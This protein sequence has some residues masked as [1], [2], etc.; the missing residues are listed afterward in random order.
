[1]PTCK[2]A[3]KMP[4]LRR[5]LRGF[6]GAQIVAGPC[7]NTT[8]VNMR[9][10]ARKGDKNN[11]AGTSIFV[12]MVQFAS[13]WTSGCFRVQL[14]H[15]FAVDGDDCPPLLFA[16]PIYSSSVD[17]GSPPPKSV[18][19]A[20][21][22]PFYTFSG[23]R[24]WRRLQSRIGGGNH[25][26]ELQVPFSH[27]SQSQECTLQWNI[28]KSEPILLSCILQGFSFHLYNLYPMY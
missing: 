14:A 25:E 23:W 20:L 8:F 17:S 12:C 13:R 16:A 21:S 4:G 28:Q 24:R 1:M 19:K 9:V 7:S 27:P 2:T 6:W 3:K 22:G 11:P 15:A 10:S 18:P 5:L 26:V